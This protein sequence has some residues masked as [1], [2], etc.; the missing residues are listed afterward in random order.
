MTEA[1]PL[2][3]VL[4]VKHMLLRRVPF[5]SRCPMK[6]RAHVVPPG[7]QHKG[8]R[9]RP[10]Q[11]WTNKMHARVPNFGN[12]LSTSSS[13]EDMVA[14]KPD[15]QRCSSGGHGCMLLRPAEV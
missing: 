14:A 8:A 13:Q 1:M 3:V 11:L 4:L 5:H 9:A 12:S 10:H 2:L 15:T 6:G 7:V